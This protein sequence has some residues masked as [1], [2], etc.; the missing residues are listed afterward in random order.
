MRPLAHHPRTPARAEQSPRAFHLV[1]STI[2][3][4]RPAYFG[5][6]AARPPTP[7]FYPRAFRRLAPSRRLQH[8]LICTA[9]LLV[10][11]DNGD[12]LKIIE[13]PAKQLTFN[14]PCGGRIHG[15]SAIQRFG[16]GQM[17]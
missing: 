2:L 6:P 3:Y 12:P 11:H 1:R 14:H 8:Y 4:R 17:Q 15:T 10:R 13:P 16:A 7:R 5:G 9:A